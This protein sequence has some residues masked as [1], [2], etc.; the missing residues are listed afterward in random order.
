MTTSLSL[1]DNLDSPRTLFILSLFYFILLLFII[2]FSFILLLFY[3]HLFYFYLFF[4]LS[5]EISNIVTICVV[6]CERTRRVILRIFF[7][8][9][10]ISFFSHFL[11]LFFVIFLFFFFFLNYSRNF[12]CVVCFNV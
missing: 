11:F 1:L 8:L 4:Y 7:S 12:F 10:Y 9:S 6:S 5:F 3:F 2:L